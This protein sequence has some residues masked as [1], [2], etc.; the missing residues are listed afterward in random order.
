MPVGHKLIHDRDAAIDFECAMMQLRKARDSNGLLIRLGPKLDQGWNP[1]GLF[2]AVS[3]FVERYGPHSNTTYLK[4]TMHT[5]IEKDSDGELTFAHNLQLL[6]NA[7][8]A[9]VEYDRVR[10]P[11]N[12]KTPV[13]G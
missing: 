6:V 13:P 4:G 3:E 1:K 2:A 8:V 11:T 5:G 10:E 7:Y 12:L 9:A